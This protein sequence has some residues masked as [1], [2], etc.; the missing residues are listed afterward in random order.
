[1][2]VKKKHQKKTRVKREAVFS[3]RLFAKQFIPSARFC[4]LRVLSGIGRKI[5]SDEKLH[6]IGLWRGSLGQTPSSELKSQSLWFEVPTLAKTAESGAASV[7][8]RQG[9]AKKVWASSPRK[10]LIT[11]RDHWIDPRRPS[12]GNPRG[13]YRRNSQQ[14]RRCRKCDWIIRS[15]ALELGA[16]HSPKH[17][18]NG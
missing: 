6:S 8:V 14:Q 3:C 1:V 4:K 13:K 5:M 9:K 7:G 16:D 17:K 18:A 2:D 10:L 15:H 11:E 12:S